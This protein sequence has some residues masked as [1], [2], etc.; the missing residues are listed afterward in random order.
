MKCQ[1]KWIDSNGNDTPDDNEAIGF[2]S[3]RNNGGEW[4]GSFPICKAKAAGK[5]RTKRCGPWFD[6]YEEV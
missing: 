5:A 1:I 3:V 2:A 4:R 6:G